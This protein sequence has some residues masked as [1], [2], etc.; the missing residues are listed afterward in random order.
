[1]KKAGK[2]GRFLG[3]VKNPLQLPLRRFAA[4]GEGKRRPLRRFAAKGEGRAPTLSGQGRKSQ[5]S[6][7]VPAQ[8]E[9]ATIFPSPLPDY[10]SS[11]GKTPKLQSG[12]AAG[13]RQM[14]G[15]ARGSWRGFL[16]APALAASLLLAGCSLP[17]FSFHGN[18][19]PPPNAGHGKTNGYGVA[20]ITPALLKA[21]A[22]RREARAVGQTNPALKQ[23][24]SDYNYEVEPQDVIAVTVWGH[25]EFTPGQSAF[26]G[27]AALKNGAVTLSKAAPPG[28]GGFTVH[29]DGNIYFPYIGRLQV[30][31]LTTAQIRA[32]IAKQLKAYIPKPQINVQVLGFHS[33]TYELSGSVAKPGLYPVTNVPMTVSK[34][35]QEAGGI[36]QTVPNVTLAAKASATPLADLSHVLYIHDGKREVLNLQ[37][38]F[39]RGDESE[40]RLIHPGDIIHVP[41]NSFDQVHII[42]EVKVPGNY[43]LH[44][45]KL[46][47]AQALGAAGGVN[48][49]TAN[50]SRIFVFR[51]AYSQPKIFW[52]DARSP[53]AMLMATQFKLRP[54]DV[55]FV[56]TAGISTFN[57]IVTQILPFVQTL[58]ETK[59]L[60]N[61]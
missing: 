33:Q 29:P 39:L 59:V 16:L 25:P 48:L 22:L 23:A 51:G 27:F 13:L 4:K 1:M 2:N 5:A 12:L 49:T 56:A 34:A 28:V 26:T 11:T 14:S 31:G 17:G 55:V 42:G 54:Q 9:G 46:N 52:L 10:A 36:L 7:S 18:P 35:I 38:F 32:K 20:R 24:L 58:Y 41:D 53:A 45:G 8:R 19:N 30:A 3:A 37:S 15:Q 61:Q 44:Y 60:V 40:D 43:P 57:R 21:Q 47:L 50:P 6:S